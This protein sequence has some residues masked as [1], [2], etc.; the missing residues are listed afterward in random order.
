MV[1]FLVG[2]PDKNG[3]AV[4]SRVTIELE[5]PGELA[6]LRFPQVANRQLQQLLDKQNRGE[7]LSLAERR[8]AERLVGLAETLSLLRLRAKRALTRGKPSA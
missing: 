4:S 6:L 1:Q 5:I 8:E 7:P 3:G 2:R